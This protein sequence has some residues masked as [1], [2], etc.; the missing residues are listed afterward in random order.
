MW[1][2]DGARILTAEEG[3]CWFFGAVDHLNGEVV[4]HH[5]CKRGDRFAALEPVAQG[6]LRHCGSLEADAGRSLRLRM[7]HGAQHVSDHFRNQVRFW[8]VQASYSF[9]E[10][11]QTNGI[12]ERFMRTLK[13]QVV[14][15]RIFRTVEEVRAAVDAFVALYNEQWLLEK[16]GFLSPSAARD[17]WRQ[18]E[19]LETAAQVRFVSSYPGALQTNRCPQ[20]PLPPD[21]TRPSD[22]TQPLGEPA[23]RCGSGR[24]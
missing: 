18:R 4:G 8:G 16:N 23:L 22:S 24:H 7:D 11:P 15:G 14:H 1:G 19:A 6:L 2:A 12:A 10:Q 20:E 3:W 5:V 9:I 13:E 17:A 21:G